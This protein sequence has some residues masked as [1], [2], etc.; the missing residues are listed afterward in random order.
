MDNTTLIQIFVEHIVSQKFSFLSNSNL[1]IEPATD[2]LQLI[3]ASGGIIA[4]SRYCDGQPSIS[5]R[6][7]S[8]YW[9]L[10]HDHMVQA[11]FL[12]VD[13]SQLAGFYQYQQIATPPGYHI[14]FSDALDILQSWWSGQQHRDTPSLAMLILHQ[15]HWHAVDTLT[16]QQG[17]LIIRTLGTT[18]QL[19]PLDRIVW[20]QQKPHRLG[21]PA[22]SENTDAG[23][24][25]ALPAATATER[26]E[27]RPLKNATSLGRLKRIGHYLIDAA[28]LTPAQVEVAL[29]DQQATGLRFGEILVTRGWLKEQTIEFLM[30]H[31]I[32][33][34]RMTATRQA[35]FAAQQLRKRL[36]QTAPSASSPISPAAIHSRETLVINNEQ[37][38]LPLKPDTQ[39]AA[40]ARHS[41]E[42]VTTESSLSRMSLTPVS[43]AAEGITDESIN[44]RKT[45]I[46]Y[47]Q[48]DL[49]DLK[50]WEQSDPSSE[51]DPDSV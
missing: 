18:V 29:C 13:K 7:Q 50:S 46:T 23:A 48:L 1:R 20:L 36:E 12:P 4:V 21:E 37:A 51:S 28:L 2:T 49:E 10:V 26:P 19:H 34:Q 14:Q 35:A 47:E 43:T 44:D 16:V 39:P 17:T 5:I 40:D 9:K 33:S 25:H 3:S 11:G 32:M 15:R 8:S 41:R 6:Q 31:V 38:S 27:S 42:T 30:D 45:L 22:R 24:G